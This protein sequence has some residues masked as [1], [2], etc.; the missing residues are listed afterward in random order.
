[1]VEQS[2]EAGARACLG[3]EREKK[4]RI[5]SRR[6]VLPSCEKKEGMPVNQFRIHG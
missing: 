4:N 1:M 2:N 5:N 3:V 6:H